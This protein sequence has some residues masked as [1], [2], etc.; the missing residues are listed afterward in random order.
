MYRMKPEYY[1][2]V[3]LID[4]EH[5]RLFE[6]ADETYELLHD[7]FL[8]YKTDRIVSLVSELID[9]ARTHFAH[10]EAYQKSIQYPHM[11]EHA[12]QHRQFEDSL[13]ELDLDSLSD[14]FEEQNET[15]ESILEFLINWLVNHILKV[16]MLLVGK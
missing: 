3:D 1:T 11:A 7:S 16:D 6:L 12:A 2:G 4:R 13:T 10:E 9:Y 15:I 5:T 8:E 14:D